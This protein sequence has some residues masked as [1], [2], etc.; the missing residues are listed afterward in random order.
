[1]FSTSLAAVGLSTPVDRII[2]GR[3]L[4][5]LLTAQTD[6]SPHETLFFYKGRKLVGVRSGVIENIT[7]ATP[8]ITAP[9]LF[10]R[11]DPLFDLRTDP[12]E[13]YNLLDDHPDLAEHLTALLDSEDRAREANP[14]GWL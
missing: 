5:P 10:S 2:D 11:R 4:P 13:S 1:M 12:R 6:A 8:A 7:A 3:N 14:R 9:I